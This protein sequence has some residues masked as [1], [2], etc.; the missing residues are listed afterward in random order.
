MTGAEIRA[1]AAPFL[2]DVRAA[3]PASA[4]LWVCGIIDR[5][6]LF[7]QALEL[8]MPG[9]L[10]GWGDKRG[11]K[12]HGFGGLQKDT[13]GGGE[14]LIRGFVPGVDLWTTGGQAS[15]VHYHVESSKRIISAAFPNLDA[16]KLLEASLCAY[17]ADIGAVLLA[18]KERRD[19]NA[20][21]TGGD[22][23]SDVLL[24]A[25]MLAPFLET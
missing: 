7:G 6:S 21:T 23:G 12:Y 16:V 5:E 13:G 2:A 14:M 10:I 19:P 4:V 22:Y 15:F 20:L 9:T 3:V 1:R 18:L 24:R 11:G 8:R 25:A 17:N